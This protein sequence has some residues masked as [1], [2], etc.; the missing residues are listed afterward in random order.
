MTLQEQ[1]DSWESELKAAGSTE[2][3]LELLEKLAFAHAVRYVRTGLP[4]GHKHAYDEETLDDQADSHDELI[5]YV[6]SLPVDDL[7]DDGDRVFDF[8]NER[9]DSAN[10]AWQEIQELQHRYRVAQQKLEEITQARK[11]GH[12]KAEDFADYSQR[13]EWY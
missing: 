12:F 1:I 11:L 7:V 9:V 13:P 8:A 3:T 4:R 5:E 2:E 6:A 10:E